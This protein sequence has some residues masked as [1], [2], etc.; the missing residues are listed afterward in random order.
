MMPEAVSRQWDNLK[1][2]IAKSLPEDER[3]EQTLVNILEG[4]LKNQIMCWISYDNQNNNQ[5]NFVFLLT[6]LEDPFKQE[7]NLLLYTIT[8]MEMLDQPT[9]LRMYQEGYV[10]LKKFMKKA[11]YAHV[12]GF[13][14]EDNIGLVDRA[15]AF[16]AKFRWHWTLKMED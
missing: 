2:H 3:G 14:N 13:I 10:A 5:V 12:I 8:R 4:I 15:K 16:G 6:T 11:G 1:L 7:R 9:A